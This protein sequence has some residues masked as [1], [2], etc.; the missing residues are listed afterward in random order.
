MTPDSGE[1]FALAG[2]H[3]REAADCALTA[4][5]VPVKQVQSHGATLCNGL[6][7]RQE[8]WVSLVP[9]RAL[10]KADVARGYV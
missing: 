10:P 3:D 2:G 4:L 7:D 5:V 1:P 9:Q 8:Q 6:A